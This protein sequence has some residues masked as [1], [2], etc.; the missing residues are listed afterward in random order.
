MTTYKYGRGVERRSIENKSIPI[1][2]SPIVTQKLPPYPFGNQ[3]RGKEL[4]SCVCP[5]LATPP[6]LHFPLL[7]TSY[8]NDYAFISVSSCNHA[9][10]VSYISQGHSFRR[11]AGIIYTHQSVRGNCG[12]D[13][14]TWACS[15]DH[16]LHSP[17]ARWRQCSFDVAVR[18]KERNAVH[19]S[20]WR[21]Q[22]GTW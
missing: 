9:W 14:Q 7:Q 10:L 18:N 22:G 20:L 15:A 8:E 12:R 17:E 11:R 2:R 19:T 5:L 13:K 21:L 6:P 1:R 16:Q 4:L 3:G